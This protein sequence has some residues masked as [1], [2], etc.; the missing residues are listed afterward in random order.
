[1]NNKQKRKFKI[2][3]FC[4]SLLMVILVTG[5]IGVYTTFYY[6]ETDKAFL[7]KY[8]DEN[9]E[10]NK[11]LPFEQYLDKALKLEYSYVSN[12]AS[13]QDLGLSYRDPDTK[14]TYTEKKF[15]SYEDGNTNNFYKNNVM[16]VESYFDIEL[17]LIVSETQ[18]EKGETITSLQYM[19]FFYNMD[20]TKMEIESANE[21]QERIR[22]V[23]VEGVNSKDSDDYTDDEEK[24]GDAAL[25]EMLTNLE[26]S[27]NYTGAPSVIKFSYGYTATK[28][29]VDFSKSLRDKNATVNLDKMEKSEAFVQKLNLSVGVN[30]NNEYFDDMESA[31]FSIILLNDDGEEGFTNLVEGTVSNILSIDEM[32]KRDTDKGYNNVLHKSP[33]FVKYTWT[34]IALASGIA[35][36]LSGVLATLFYMIWI[37]EKAPTQKGKKQK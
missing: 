9:T 30:P 6:G 2:I 29:S 10:E 15:D 35:F 21:A 24:E 37:D 12:A 19:F 18:N 23:F 20:Y 7:N 25:E 4:I 34:K 1:M 22:I 33:L 16:H 3:P 36:V 14:K 8:L 5:G 17:K 26:E 28:K 11:N 31:T 13:Q 32:Q 27:S